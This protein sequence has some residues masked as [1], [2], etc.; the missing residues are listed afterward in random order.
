MATLTKEYINAMLA[1]SVNE[2]SLKFECIEDITYSSKSDYKRPHFQIKSEYQNLYFEKY[3]NTDYITQQYH[4]G[5]QWALNQTFNP[6]ATA[7]S[8]TQSSTPQK[9]AYIYSK[10]ENLML[11]ADG[12]FVG[13][14]GQGVSMP[15]KYVGFG[16]FAAPSVPTAVIVNNVANVTESHTQ[17]NNAVTIELT[18]QTEYVGF[19][20]PPTATYTDTGNTIRDVNATIT[21]ANARVKAT[22]NLTNVDTSVNIVLNGAIERRISCGA[23][24]EHATISGIDTTNYVYESDVSTI[25]LTAANGYTF[26]TPPTLSLSANGS[27]VTTLN[28]TINGNTATITPDLSQYPTVTNLG[29][30]GVATEQTFTFVNNIANGNLQTS[31]S[32]N[33]I[34]ATITAN[35][36][37][38]KYSTAP[39]V[40]YYSSGA[41]VTAAMTVTTVNDYVTATATIIADSGTNVTFDGVL[42]QYFEVEYNLTNAAKISGKT[43]VFVTE[44][45]LNIEVTANANYCF[46][47]S[48]TALVSGVSI[49]DTLPFTFE[50]TE[51]PYFTASIS[52]DL[53]EYNRN[54][55][56]VIEVT[57]AAVPLVAYNYGAIN[58]YKV[59]KANINA[60]ANVRFTTIQN[61]SGDYV[62][63]AEYVITLKRL[64][65]RVGAT[66][67]D[68]I[69]CQNYDLHINA[70]TPVIDVKTIN[71]GVVTVP[72]VAENASDYT[73]TEITLFLPFVGYQTISSDYLNKEITL[74]YVCSAVTG[75]GYSKLICDGITFA[76]YECEVSD[77]MIFEKITNNA[78][79]NQLQFNRLDGLQPYAIVKRYADGNELLYNADCERGVIGTAFNGYCEFIEV[80]NLAI[81]EIS[82]SEKTL[83][84][85]LLSK[86]VIV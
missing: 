78:Q 60:F 25:T 18:T 5:T 49:Y 62:D 71:C 2:L 36:T 9:Y 65:F 17:N 64:Y 81:S 1:N 75:K 10:V 23:Y 57:A 79:I 42:T 26:A 74:Q 27:V 8:T 24:L 85:D 39:S 7:T 56:H 83:I 77:N 43:T 11:I 69:K 73:N 14:P 3:G 84:V 40:A 63:L 29:V 58:V 72:Y 59:T 82:E 54:Y 13:D 45:A 34:T 66:V 76:S 47:I 6:C 33:T 80:E 70:A 35:A 31:V 51:E 61:S 53:T 30:I 55:I 16:D 46:E 28:F 38:L 68:T 20:T 41:L 86:G 67:E 37:N 19:K 21:S 22:W 44:T 12:G 52:I 48:P 4:D 15:I 50:E 32:G